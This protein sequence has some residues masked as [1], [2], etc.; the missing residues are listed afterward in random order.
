MATNRLSFLSGTLPK[1]VLREALG[2]R[3]SLALGVPEG[4]EAAECHCPG[5]RPPLAS[6]PEDLGSV[7]PAS[8]H[9]V[10]PLP[11]LAD[12][13][14]RFPFREQRPHPRSCSGWLA[15]ALPQADG[16]R[17]LGRLLPLGR[18]CFHRCLR[19]SL[20]PLDL[21]LMWAFCAT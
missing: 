13:S 14:L 2:G 10:H 7:L 4:R 17:E 3:A 5:P 1:S 15:G 20:S 9:Q 16:A 8:K 12:D 21:P 18:G 6:G 11:A 19:H